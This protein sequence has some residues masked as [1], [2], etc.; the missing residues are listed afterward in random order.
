[1]SN[2]PESSIPLGPVLRA[3]HT[4]LNSFGAPD[5]ISCGK[6]ALETMRELSRL[7][8]TSD[9]GDDFVAAWER[10]GKGDPL[11]LSLMEGI[12]KLFSLGYIVIG[13][14]KPG[15]PYR[16]RITEKGQRWAKSE[17]PVP[18]WGS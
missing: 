2:L 9:P 15:D 13:P 7:G 12:S 1:M 11:E 10:L 6:W 17:A 3:L 5:E 14:G 16:Y 4:A 8:L 18:K